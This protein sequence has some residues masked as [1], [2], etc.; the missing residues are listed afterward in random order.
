MF[1]ISCK[2]SGCV[3]LTCTQNPKD[4]MKLSP[5]VDTYFNILEFD[6]NT[7]Y[8]GKY[9]KVVNGTLVD[10]GYKHIAFNH[11]SIAYQD[12]YPNI[13]PL[14]ASMYGRMEL[15]RKL[16]EIK[17]IV[18]SN[19]HHLLGCSLPQEFMAYKDWKFIK[20]VDTSN[21]ILVGAE[22]KRYTDSG[23]NWKPKEKLEYYFEKDLSEQKEDIIFN[24][25]KFKQF[26]K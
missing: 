16:V 13:E 14:K 10:L 8:T 18:K 23:L 7:D 15:I 25:Q 24:V 26:I 4:V 2:E 12:M 5:N 11:S 17:A 21:P 19:Y 20:S 3:K 22:G 6:D 9:L 1:V